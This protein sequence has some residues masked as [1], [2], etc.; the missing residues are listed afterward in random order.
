MVESTVN[1]SAMNDFGESRG[2]RAWTFLTNHGHVFFLLARNSDLRLRDIA[3]AVGVTERATFGII[4]D[5]EAG[6]YVTR[7]RAGRR[8]TYTVHT[9]QPLRHPLEAGTPVGDIVNALRG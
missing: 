8:N 5:L 3:D 2:E 9:D 6:G 4:S 7:Q 1:G